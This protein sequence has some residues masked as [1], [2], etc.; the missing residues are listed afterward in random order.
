MGWQE[1]V[2]QTI[3]KLGTVLV[4]RRF[5]AAVAMIVISLAG[6]FGVS[7]E[8]L[9]RINEAFGEE[10]E[11]IAILAES[12]IGAIV[13]LVSGVKVI[14]SW[15]QRP[16]SGLD[17]EKAKDIPPIPVPPVTNVVVPEEMVNTAVAVEVRRMMD[18][19][20]TKE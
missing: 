12:I 16:P 13:V 1:K 15:T 2:S 4:D 19:R 6:A 3:N 18:E 11:T 20:L 9:D 17:Y 5:W 10:G 8:N 14:G 7:Q